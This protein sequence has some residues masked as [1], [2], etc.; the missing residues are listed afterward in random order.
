[1]PLQKYLFILKYFKK[2]REK[3]MRR[4]SD[5]AGNEIEEERKIYEKLLFEKIAK[6]RGKFCR[7][8]HAYH[9]LI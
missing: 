7:H 6:R 9:L 1:M 2:V 8:E 5:L 3:K 4:E